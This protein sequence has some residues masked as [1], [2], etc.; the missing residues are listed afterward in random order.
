[1][2]DVPVRVRLS[3]R[4]G[5][6]RRPELT[7]TGRPGDARA[8]L[9]A[10]DAGGDDQVTEIGLGG[11]VDGHAAP[12]AVASSVRLKLA[13]IRFVQGRFDDAL[14]QTA[15]V[16]ATPQLPMRAYSIARVAALYA[17]MARDD[18]EGA[19]SAAQAILA[20]GG[21]PEEDVAL[22]GAFAALGWVAW[23]EGRARDAVGML[24]AAVQRSDLGFVDGG[25]SHPRL[26][27]APILAAVGDFSSARAVV[28]ECRFDIEQSSDTL[29]AP[30]AAIALAGIHLAA[31]CLDDAETEAAA[32]LATIDELGAFLF[33]ATAEFTLARVELCRGNLDQAGDHAR[34]MC[35]AIADGGGSSHAKASC[36]WLEAQLIGR[37]VG[38][39]EAVTS[40]D[41]LY[42]RIADHKPLLMSEPD[43]SVWLVRTA[44]AAGDPRRAE[45]VI[46]LAESL[47]AENPEVEPL[48]AIASHARGLLDGDDEKLR[49]AASVHPQPWSAASASEDAGA[50]LG[51]RDPVAAKV[52][53]DEA[54]S[55]FEAIGAT[56][57]AARVRTRLQCVGRRRGRRVERKVSGWASLTETEQE[58]ARFVAEGMTNRQVAERMY[59]S[60]HTIDFHLRAVFRKLVVAS[61]VELA[62]LVLER[63]ATLGGGIGRAAA[64]A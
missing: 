54:L 11:G 15:A 40:M 6:V 21:H 18:R 53:F 46:V 38:P 25:V 4:G 56:L 39:A 50:A 36:A 14:E 64:G 44:Q 48:A 2:T 17:L 20:G 33:R 22:G 45:K 29:W 41:W 28:E 35:V 62:R 59:L 34:R 52:W 61:R 23:Q 12:A 5:A 8:V 32:A 43:A 42:E 31:G 26:V 16:L 19:R 1:M 63:G 55:R 7:P 9:R 13:S 60:R 24:R 37:L 3:T 51:P 27:L 10:V 58:V 57:D 47:A 49:W 30:G